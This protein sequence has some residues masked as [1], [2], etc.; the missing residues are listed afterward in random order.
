MAEMHEFFR[1]SRQYE[2]RS[3]TRSLEAEFASMGPRENVAFKKASLDLDGLIPIYVK[4]D[5]E[6][7]KDILKFRAGRIISNFLN[8]IGV[9]NHRRI[10]YQARLYALFNRRLAKAKE[11]GQE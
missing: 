7:E 8:E 4:C 9:T 6:K 11:E 1:R 10:A 5:K 3:D 2:A